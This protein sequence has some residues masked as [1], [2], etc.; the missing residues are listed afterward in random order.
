LE[1]ALRL[2]WVVH[3]FSRLT[4]V[5]YGVCSLGDHG[6]DAARG[7]H[8]VDGEVRGQRSRSLVE[9]TS[10]TGVPIASRVAEPDGLR[11]EEP[12]GTQLPDGRLGRR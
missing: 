4:A 6:Q 11:L 5:R 9:H 12:G 10:Y 3:G 2:G 7:G 8:V 1:Q